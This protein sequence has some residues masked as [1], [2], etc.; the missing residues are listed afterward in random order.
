MVRMHVMPRIFPGLTH[1]QPQRTAELS[2]A[3]KEFLETLDED[4]DPAEITAY[5]SKPG[6]WFEVRDT[7]SLSNTGG[8][9]SI[10]TM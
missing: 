4:A 10:G 9:V 8:T 1:P 2:K 6:S 7:G 5:W 3:L